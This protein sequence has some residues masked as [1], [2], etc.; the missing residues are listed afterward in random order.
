MLRSVGVTIRTLLIFGFLLL[1][2]LMAFPPVAQWVES[3]A[4]S[5]WPALTGLTDR[6]LAADD[7]F[8]PS[9]DADWQTIPPPPQDPLVPPSA[10]RTV[11]V[12]R[13]SQQPD[14]PSGRADVQDQDLLL[15][16]ELEQLARLG[17]RAGR[18]EVGANS[19][20]WFVCHVPLDEGG[21][22]ARRFAA[23]ADE[24]LASLRQVRREIESW[25]QLLRDRQGSVEIE[26]GLHIPAE[27]LLRGRGQHPSPSH[28]S[29]DW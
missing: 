14:P 8:A 12:Q 19:R 1:M 2:P 18:W 11:P 3:R 20:E 22:Y 28:D 4:N 17:A 5:L 27:Q 24:R 29:R 21:V 23:S 9:P 6:D 10:G 7:S 15:S 25:R 13:V 26:V 16:M